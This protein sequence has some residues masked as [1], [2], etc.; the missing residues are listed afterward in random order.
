M[1]DF[2]KLKSVLLSFPSLGCRNSKILSSLFGSLL[3]SCVPLVLTA[4]QWP[5]PECGDN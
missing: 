4:E 2:F 3:I 5:F 1:L